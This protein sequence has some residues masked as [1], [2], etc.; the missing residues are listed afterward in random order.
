[1]VNCTWDDP[2]KKPRPSGWGNNNVPSQ[3]Q[4]RDPARDAF[5]RVNAMGA[6][7]PAP[8]PQEQQPGYHYPNNENQPYPSNNIQDFPEPQVRRA[9]KNPLLEF[10]GIVKRIGKDKVKRRESYN[11]KTI[12]RDILIATGRHPVQRPLNAHLEPLKAFDK[13]DAKADLSTFR[14]DIVD[15]G[16]AENGSANKEDNMRPSRGNPLGM[17]EKEHVP[18]KL[19][20]VFMDDDDDGIAYSGDDKD[21]S[22]S[23]EA[24]K[25]AVSDWPKSSPFLTDGTPQGSAK[26]PPGRPRKDGLPAGSASANRRVS[27]RET[28]NA[29]PN[30]RIPTIAEMKIADSEGRKAKPR[31]S[32]AAS[33]A[34]SVDTVRE[35]PSPSFTLIPCAWQDCGK[36]F[37]NVET[38]FKHV[39]QLHGQGG[40]NAR[41]WKCLW[42]GCGDNEFE[43]G[44]E[45]SM[46][47]VFGDYKNFLGH[48]EKNH[49]KAMRYLYGDGIAADTLGMSYPSPLSS[50]LTNA[51]TDGNESDAT[52][53]SSRYLFD[54]DNHRVTPS[55]ASQA[56]ED[57]DPIC[58]NS[59]RHESLKRKATDRRWVIKSRLA[60][61]APD[62]PPKKARNAFAPKR[63]EIEGLER[64]RLGLPLKR[65]LVKGKRGEMRYVGEKMRQVKRKSKAAVHR[66]DDGDVDMDDY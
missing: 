60:K 19:R 66:G 57:G 56:S 53:A 26:R 51:Q 39:D 28:K 38:L 44:N 33:V 1:M 9:V 2:S 59:A 47:P 29:A 58:R 18:S 23:K 16:G 54:S 50:A 61:F 13:V 4:T 3:D 48:V 8:Y 52:L 62:K 41:A 25:A 45:M 22:L 42:E 35:Y 63:G 10:Q 27:A 55:V 14:W 24:Y 21:K 20:H 64:E 31:R 30:Y 43:A 34:S 11:P 49:M 46:G 32:R 65:E 37:Q 7:A 36:R 12:A 40:K 15:P 5:N 6:P 17:S